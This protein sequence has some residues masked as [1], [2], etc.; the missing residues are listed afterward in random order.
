MYKV[1]RAF[2]DS[3]DKNRFYRVGDV[4]PVEGA[5]TTKS[6]VKVLLIGENKNNKVYIEEVS[7]ET[8]TEVENGSGEVEQE[9]EETEESEETETEE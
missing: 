6:R 1:I 5:K 4:Y 3:T 9:T 7:E 2:R 8:E